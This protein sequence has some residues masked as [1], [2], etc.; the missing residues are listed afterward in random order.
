M[1]VPVRHVLLFPFP[2]Y[3]RPTRPFLSI[4]PNLTTFLQVFPNHVRNPF[5][6]RTKTGQRRSFRRPLQRGRIN[7]INVGRHLSLTFVQ[8]FNGTLF[9]PTS[10][11]YNIPRH[12]IL[13]TSRRRLS[14]SIFGKGM[15]FQLSQ[16]DYLKVIG[17][18]TKIC[19]VTN[20]FTL[21]NST[22]PVIKV[23]VTGQRVKRQFTPMKRRQ[24]ALN[25]PLLT[26]IPFTLRGT[27]PRGITKYRNGNRNSVQRRNDHYR[28]GHSNNQYANG[29]S[30]SIAIDFRP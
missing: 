23:L 17:R 29:T 30:L 5:R 13:H 11:L 15:F 1:K 20:T 7:T 26:T 25:Q 22:V 4:C 3:R 28:H 18:L 8:F 2:F 6:G 14:P 9:R 27:L 12:V 19:R 10:V 24:F 16:V 21:N